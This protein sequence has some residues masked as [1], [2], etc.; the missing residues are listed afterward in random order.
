[1]LN[2]FKVKGWHAWQQESSASKDPQASK[3]VAL[4]SPDGLKKF[5]ATFS[6]NV[7]EERSGNDWLGAGELDWTLNNGLLTVNPLHIKL[8]G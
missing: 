1:Q 2:D 7:G 8:P 3:P 4:M 5:D 6:L